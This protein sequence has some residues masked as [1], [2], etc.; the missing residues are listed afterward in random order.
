MSWHQPEGCL[1]LPGGCLPATVLVQL[2]AVGQTMERQTRLETP[3]A[4]TCLASRLT[5]AIGMGAQ[6]TG[7]APC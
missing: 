7:R 1:H 6:F 5:T 4:G 3:R 2:L